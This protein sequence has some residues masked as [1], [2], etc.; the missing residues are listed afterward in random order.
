[1]PDDRLAKRSFLTLAQA[2]VIAREATEREPVR[3][4]EA[5]AAAHA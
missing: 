4:I 5:R 2:E 1:V 3:R